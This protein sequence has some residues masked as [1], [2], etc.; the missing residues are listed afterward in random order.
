MV[1]HSPK[2]IASEEKAISTIY[3]T[4]LPAEFTAYKKECGQCTQSLSITRVYHI[5]ADH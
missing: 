3:E 4:D 5:N 1:K 2:V